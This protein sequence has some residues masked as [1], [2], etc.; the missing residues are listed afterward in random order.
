MSTRVNLECVRMGEAACL[1]AFTVEFSKSNV[2]R[3]RWS[4]EVFK[5]SWF[6]CWGRRLVTGSLCKILRGQTRAGPVPKKVVRWNGKKYVWCI[7]G[8]QAYN[9]RWE[10]TRGSEEREGMVK[11]GKE[12]LGRVVKATWWEWSGRG[13]FLV[14]LE[15]ARITCGMGKG[16]AAALCHFP[17]A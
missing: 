17:V 12:A 9:L 6:I 2:P 15:L 8:K 3:Q 16:R 5:S 11:S 10:Q 4:L 13:F 1:T 7:G 14:F